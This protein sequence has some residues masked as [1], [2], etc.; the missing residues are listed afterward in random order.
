[1]KFPP[2]Y[3]AC[4]CDR[5]DGYGEILVGITSDALSDVIDVPLHLEVCSVLLKL[6]RNANVIIICAYRPLCADTT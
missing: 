4:R 2:N 1:M 5:A 6:S 3:K